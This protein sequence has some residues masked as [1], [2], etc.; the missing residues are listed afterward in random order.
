MNFIIFIHFFRAI[1]FIWKITKANYD[2]RCYVNKFGMNS[3]LKTFTILLSPSTTVNV[4]FHSR[5]TPLVDAAL[6]VEWCLLPFLPFIHGNLF[7]SRGLYT[8]NAWWCR[9]L[10]IHW[11]NFHRNICLTVI[12]DI[13]HCKLNGQCLIDTYCKDIYWSAAIL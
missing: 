8:W 5:V 9:T 12:A 2:C 6:N 13:M 7:G 4:T 10:D 11:V 1:T 3:T